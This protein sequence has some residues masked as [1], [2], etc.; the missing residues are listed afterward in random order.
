MSAQ[1]IIFAVTEGF[2][3][4]L[5]NKEAHP[6]YRCTCSKERMEKALISIGKKELN[7]L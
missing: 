3:M 4:L 2:S 7:H 1:D 6:E 5:E